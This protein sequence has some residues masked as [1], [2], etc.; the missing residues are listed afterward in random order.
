MTGFGAE[1]CNAFLVAHS[2][3]LTK[4]Y[5]P[6]NETKLTNPLLYLYK[7]IGSSPIDG[8]LC[9]IDE[10]PFAILFSIITPAPIYLS[11]CQ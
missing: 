6:T 4:A 8:A 7:L 3:P 11:F 2:E 10:H 5:A 1:S 9:Q